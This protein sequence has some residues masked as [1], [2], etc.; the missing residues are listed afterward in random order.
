M[1]DRILVVTILDS[2]LSKVVGETQCWLELFLYPVIDHSI[3]Q[4]GV[5]FKHFLVLLSNK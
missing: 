5:E 1:Y 2:M 3:I 4:V